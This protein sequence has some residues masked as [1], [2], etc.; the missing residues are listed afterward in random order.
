MFIILANS[1]SPF[2]ATH[3]FKR[4]KY[5]GVKITVPSPSVSKNIGFIKQTFGS[6]DTIFGKALIASNSEESNST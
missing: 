6:K 3:C 5:P 2:F 1:I 4:L